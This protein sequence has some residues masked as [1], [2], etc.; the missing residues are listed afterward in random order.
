MFFGAK[1]CTY[2]LKHTVKSRNAFICYNNQGLKLN[3][4]LYVFCMF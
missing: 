1:P 4:E 2:N 3:K